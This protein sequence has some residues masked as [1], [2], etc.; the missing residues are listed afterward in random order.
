M[1]SKFKKLPNSVISLEAS[2]SADEFK[3]YWDGASERGVWRVEQKGFGPGMAPKE[4]AEQAIN[5][6][7]VFETAL[8]D[9]VRHS[10]NSIT[11]ENDWTVIDTPKVEVVS[12]D[13]LPSDPKGV[14][15]FKAEVVVFPEINLPDYKK[16][17]RKVQADKKEVSVTDEE[18]EKSL[19]WLRKSR[20]KEIRVARP[21]KMGDVVELE[22]K[23]SVGGTPLSGGEIK[24]DKFALGDGRFIPGFEANL[25]NRKEGEEIKF[26]LTAPAD[27]WKKELQGKQL[28]FEV[29]LGAVF[30]RELAAADDA[31]AKSLGKF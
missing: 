16:I 18:I 31:F 19:D 15:K 4:I 30:E 20:A 3:P 17:A 10:L 25:E 12:A 9:A 21:A 2:L 8:E 24:H 13:C 22:I 1:E 6:E 5:K 26:S 27:Y 14:L 23:T 29:K 7:A 28:D 11:Q